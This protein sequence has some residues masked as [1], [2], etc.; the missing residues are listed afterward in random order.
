MTLSGKRTL[1][2]LAIA[3]VSIVSAAAGIDFGAALAELNVTEA[4]LTDAIAT[5][6]PGWLNLVI[7]G[8]GILLGAW[9]R[10]KATTRVLGGAPLDPPARPPSID[11]TANMLAALLGLALVIAL[12]GCATNTPGPVTPQTP[13]QALASAWL[14]HGNANAAITDLRRARVIDA[15]TFRKWAVEL[16]H[17]ES[18][19]AMAGELLAIGDEANAKTWLQRATDMLIRLQPLIQEKLNELERAQGAGAAQY[20]DQGR[21]RLS[22]RGQ[23]LPALRAGAG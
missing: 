15:G 8:V 10:V 21:H 7:A 19:L 6:S 23:Q 1:V 13:K 18:K 14:A 17:V 3:F 12:T 16:D 4:Q 20:G 5:E 11:G 22:D 2:S 9:F